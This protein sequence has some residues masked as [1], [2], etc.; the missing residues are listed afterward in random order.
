MPVELP[1][2]L[3]MKYGDRWMVEG[4]R[5]D[6]DYLTAIDLLTASP[7]A[8]GDAPFSA[9]FLCMTAD[10][11]RWHAV[12]EDTV[13]T[14]T[15]AELTVHGGPLKGQWVFLADT[16]PRPPRPAPN[17]KK[18]IAPDSI[19]RSGSC[20]SAQFTAGAVAFEQIMEVLRST[21]LAGRPG[22]K[23]VVS[24]LVG[25]PDCLRPIPADRARTLHL[26]I[27]EGTFVTARFSIGP[28]LRGRLLLSERPSSAPYDA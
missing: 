28:G 7:A 8:E 6:R 9:R 13:A 22:Q 24:A 17:Y 1:L 23:W 2:S 3:E 20:V 25:T 26:E 18:H 5:A 19:L 12:S 27:E 21:A 14:D 10:P 11:G 4:L 15:P 16:P